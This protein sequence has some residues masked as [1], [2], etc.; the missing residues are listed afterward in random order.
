MKKSDQQRVAGVGASAG[1]LE[2]LQAF[3]NHL[4]DQSGLAYVVVQHLSPDYRSMMD[5]LLA[6]H[7]RMP[8]HVIRD[9]MTVEADSV[10]LI[11]PRQNLKIY[12]NQLF[13]ERQDTGKGLNLPIDIFFRSLAEEKKK[14]AIGVI[15]S[16]TGSDGTMGTREIKEHGGLIMVQDEKSS[17]FNGMPASAISTGLVDY[18]LPPEKMGG[19][20]INYVKHPLVRQEKQSGE[21]FSGELDSVSKVMMILREYSGIDF[22]YYKENTIHR[23]LDRRVSINRFHD[24]RDYIPFLSASD[25]EKEILYRELLIGVTHFFRDKEAFESLKK[26]VIRK[27]AGGDKKQVRVWTTGCSTGEEAYTLAILFREVAEEKRFRGEI[28]LFATDID[29]KSVEIAGRGFYPDSIVADV[30]PERLSRY[31]QKVEGGYRV[32]EEIRNMIVFA[33]HNVLKDPPFS[34]LDLLVC[35]NLFIYLK[36][37][38]QSA[39]LSRFYYS[40][41]KQG[42]LFMGSS[43]TLGGMSEAFEVV[44]LKHKIYRYRSG[45]TPPVLDHIAM[46]RSR[47]PGK[48]GERDSSRQTRGELR[49]D[50]LLE[51]VVDMIVPPT[52]IIDQNYFVVNVIN[53]INPFAEIQPGTYSNE[54]FSMLPRELGLFVNNLL[55]HLKSSDEPSVS[56]TVSGLE[57]VK[58]KTLRVTGRK[59]EKKTGTYYVLSFEFVRKTRQKEKQADSR[60]VDSSSGEAKRIVELEQELKSTRENLAATVEELE[61]ANE[62]LQS[63]NEE[64]IASNEELQSTNEELQ[65]VNEELYT[66]NAEHQQKIDE[67][68]RLNND[69]NN[70]LRNTEIAAIYLDSNLRIRKLTPHVSEVTNIM[71]T[72]IGRPITH[73]SVM[74]G[75]PEI[76]ED[77]QQVMDDLKPVDKEVQDKQGNPY[78]TRLRPY[79]TENNAV[80]G[81]LITLIDTSELKKLRKQ[82]ERSSERLTASMNLGKMAWWEWEV[83]P[84]RIRY[85]DKLATMLG[86]SVSGFPDRLREIHKKVHPEDRELVTEKVNRVMEGANNR[87]VCRFRMKKKDGSY[88]WVEDHGTVKETDKQGGPVRMMGMTIDISGVR[89]MEEDLHRNEEILQLVMESSPAAITMVNDEGWITYANRRAEEFFNIDREQI[90]NRSYDASA[91]E[92]TGQD[93]QPVP[94]GELPFSRI[95]KTLEPLYGYRHYIKVP[96]KKRA[97]LSIDGAPVLSDDRRFLGAVFTLKVENQYERRKKEKSGASEKN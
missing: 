87:W 34:K 97:L 84:D 77:V 40:L 10:Y 36:P 92:I 80:D 82:V 67:L 16:G 83:K 56:R 74:D 59:T 28:K 13:L 81:V 9:G 25:G 94:A 42:Y 62:E 55:R 64:L 60:E 75:Y 3:F 35:R 26:H 78:F 45:F 96:G 93:G 86:Y 51:E 8:I 54:L 46:E 5:E 24:L 32:N 29:R 48:K 65:S 49:K 21:S 39:L 23:R 53:D 38:I 43:E 22:S 6:R 19:E 31:F 91:W 79:R 61:S 37:D 69:I 14:D 11:P 63:S 72:D 57:S 27:L 44:D 2:A 30:E 1:G 89:S 58:K 7:T 15:L 33:T 18:I 12:R 71:E 52:V 73:L 50:T 76:G 17:R 20:L 88:I 4:P 90:V 41:N 95:K 70:L 85:N 47:L 68:T 66:V